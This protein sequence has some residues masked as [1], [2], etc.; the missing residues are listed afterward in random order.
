MAKIQSHK[1]S[2]LMLPSLRQARELSGI[3][4]QQMTVHSVTTSGQNYSRRMGTFSCL[5]PSHWN[6]WGIWEFDKSILK[7]TTLNKREKP[8]SVFTGIYGLLT[9][10]L[11]HCLYALQ[12]FKK[13]IC[14]HFGF[15]NTVHLKNKIGLYWWG[16][17]RC[18]HIFKITSE[19]GSLQ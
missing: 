19:S 4:F 15:K 13:L 7:K 17:Q 1:I 9:P 2:T 5:A 18:E 8:S 16:I 3:N 6:W 10:P 12:I 14:I 11:L